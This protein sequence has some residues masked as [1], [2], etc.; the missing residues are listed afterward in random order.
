MKPNKFSEKWVARAEYDKAVSL[1]S[2]LTYN[3]EQ[4]LEIADKWRAIAESM[5][6]PLDVCHGL[7]FVIPLGILTGALL[8]VVTR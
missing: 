8:A 5:L 4:S 7:V 2:E 6:N 1:C 3:G